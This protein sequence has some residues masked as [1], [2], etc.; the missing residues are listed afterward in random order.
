MPHTMPDL[1]ADL[2][3]YGTLRFPDVLEA[4]LGRVPEHSPAI[5]PGWRVAALDGRVYPVLVPG[6]GAAGGIL[7]SGL[8]AEEWQVIDAYEDS[9][10]SL[11]RVSL[12]GGR[13]GWAYLTR[14]GTTGLPSDWSPDDFT[15]RHLDGFTGACREWRRAYG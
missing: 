6:P 9:F 14:D 13:A 3:A 7:I 8:T 5:A 1:P 4:L 12:V 2:F 11:E 10:Y 15:L